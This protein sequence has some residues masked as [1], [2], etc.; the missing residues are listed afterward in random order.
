[1]RKHSH[2][3]GQVKSR[4]IVSRQVTD[5]VGPIFFITHAESA[6]L[7]IMAGVK[8]ARIFPPNRGV[9]ATMAGVGKSVAVRLPPSPAPQCRLSQLFSLDVTLP[10][11][12]SPSAPLLACSLT[13]PW[14]PHKDVSS[15]SSHMPFSSSRRSYLLEY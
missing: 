12:L 2:Q 13:P 4:R 15:R 9:P 5:G 1:M 8:K 3:M 6:V 10:P 7:F 14:P 11:S